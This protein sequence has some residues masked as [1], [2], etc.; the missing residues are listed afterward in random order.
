MATVEQLEKQLARAREERN[1]RILHVW[2]GGLTQ[3][4]IARLEGLT[5]ERVSQILRAAGRGR[6]PL[7]QTT[8]AASPDGDAEQE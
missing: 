6:L 4:Q 1:E 5:L 8:P 7:R 3:T 2:H